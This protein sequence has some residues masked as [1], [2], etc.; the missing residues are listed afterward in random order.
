[1]YIEQALLGSRDIPG[2][3]GDPILNGIVKKW[4]F[5]P[6]LSRGNSA[7]HLGPKFGVFGVF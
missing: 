1:M 7:N 3:N 5:E 2:N 6:I 4:F